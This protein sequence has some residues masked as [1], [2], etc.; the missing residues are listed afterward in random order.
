MVPDKLI[1]GMSI[2]QN[3]GYDQ[4]SFERVVGS[5]SPRTFGQIAYFDKHMFQLSRDQNPTYVQR[6]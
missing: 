4:S 2:G 3:Y 5:S 6:I 1:F